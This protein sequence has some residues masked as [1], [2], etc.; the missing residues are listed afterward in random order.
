MNLHSSCQ[1]MQCHNNK[2]ENLLFCN[3]VKLLTTYLTNT[4]IIL[5]RTLDRRFLIFSICR[6][7]EDNISRH[8]LIYVSNQTIPIFCKNSAIL[9]FRMMAPIEPNLPPLI[10][11]WHF[12]TRFRSCNIK[13]NN[14]LKQ[15]SV[16]YV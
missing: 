12:E 13:R 15:P 10:F 7:S 9:R 1:T 8:M 14:Y 2:F 3:P 4:T 5:C 16:I 6:Y 11:L